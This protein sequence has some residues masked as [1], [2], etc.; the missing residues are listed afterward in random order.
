MP[1]SVHGSQVTEYR[2]IYDKLESV[3][4][5]DGAQCTVDSTFGKDLIDIPS[6]RDQ[7]IA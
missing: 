4:E 3:C 1:G 7:G 6:Y 5:R 2:K